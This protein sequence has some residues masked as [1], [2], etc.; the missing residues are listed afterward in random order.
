[1]S[2]NLIDFSFAFTAGIFSFFSPCGY[3]LLPG[4]ISYYLGSKA[5]IA[6]AISGSLICALGL[7]TV[8][9]IMGVLAS[10]VSA[11][12]ST[13]VPLLNLAA[14]AIIILMGVSMLLQLKIGMLFPIRISRREG[15]LGLFTFGIAYGFAVTGCSAPI[16]LSVL[17]YAMT[18][19]L[20]NGAA[21]FISYAMGMAFPLIITGILSAKSKELVMK[22]AVNLVPK[23]QK[24]SGA[25]LIILGMYLFYL[26]YITYT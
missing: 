8:F 17:F 13:L 24:I 26:Y 4:Y 3:P 10:T 11:I 18:K 12:L 2:L 25:F 5:P 1:M 20:F 9:S 23:I 14:G 16:F 7:V 21:T 15:F 19:G 22:K 6:K